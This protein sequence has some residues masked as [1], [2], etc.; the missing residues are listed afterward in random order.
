M[1]EERGE[2]FEESKGFKGFKEFEGVECRARQILSR[3]R[4]SGSG[5]GRVGGTL[6]VRIDTITMDCRDDRTLSA[7]WTAAFGYEV[8]VDPP[9]GWM[10]LR[11]PSGTGPSIGLQCVPEP[12]VVKNRVQLDLIPTDDELEA[13]IRR[14]ESLGAQRVRYVE[15]DTNESHWIMADPEGNE[16]CCEWPPW[17]PQPPRP[18]SQP[19]ATRSAVSVID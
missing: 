5:G 19:L 14:L 10:V 6:A 16:F 12:K 18:E 8:A 13:E 9:G 11:D 2:G 17:E 15:S 4:R 7:F 1:L 3:Q